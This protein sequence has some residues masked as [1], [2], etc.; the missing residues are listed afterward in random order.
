M[1]PRVNVRSMHNAMRTNLSIHEVLPSSFQHATRRDGILIHIS[2][3]FFFHRGI[4]SY[5][6]VPCPDR[7]RRA[8]HAC[9]APWI[10]F[11]PTSIRPTQPPI[12]LGDVSTIASS[13]SSQY[14][15]FSIQPQRHAQGS[16]TTRVVLFLRVLLCRTSSTSAIS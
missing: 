12:G 11:A 16:R 6:P 7:R 15:P 4:K 10:S 8:A 13:L 9:L 5:Y 2:Q 14:N 1:N 3:A